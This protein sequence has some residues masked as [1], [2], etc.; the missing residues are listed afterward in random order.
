MADTKYTYSVASDF[1]QGAVSPE[2]FEQEIHDSSISSA[3]YLYLNIAGDVCDVWFDGA[4]SGGDETTL[5]GIVAAHEAVP[6]DPH[7]DGGVIINPLPTPTGLAVVPQ[8]T[9]GSTSWGYCITAY[10]ATGETIECEEVLISNGAATLNSTNYNR[11]TWDAVPGAVKYGV[12]RTTS[13]GS[14]SSVGRTCQ[15]TS[16]ACNDKGKVASGSLPSEDISGALVLGGEVTAS[17]GKKLDIRELTSDDST[18]T[19]LVAITRRSSEVVA[20]GFGTGLYVRLNDDED[21]LRDAG[22]M[23]FLWSDP[24]SDSPD[25]DFRVMLRDGGG[26]MEERLK[27]TSGGQLHLAGVTVIQLETSR[28]GFP[29]DIGI[30]G[31]SAAASSNNDVPSVTFAATAE[32]RLRW[33]CR[34][35]QNYSSGDLTL[36][37]LCSFAGTAGDTGVRWQL[38]W[39]CLSAGDT[40]PASYQHSVAFTENEND[41]TN[42]VL[43]NVDFTIPAAQFDK[44]KDML[45]LWLRRDGDHTGDTCTLVVHVHM[46]ELRYTGRTM[47]GQPG[48]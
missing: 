35:P 31:G 16:T 6:L 4:L 33:T 34:P 8:G 37:A 38:D 5:D 10:S 20:A 43:F 2:T 15:T 44:T 13:G 24:D 17:G 1:P 28:V 47:A 45:A 46:C 3:T 21:V 9:P 30:R 18:V 22:A 41:K 27:I 29:V 48:Q 12:Y 23:H 7:S 14:P 19:S 36:R 40:L 39:S 26:S 25:S 42:D 32:S 11:L